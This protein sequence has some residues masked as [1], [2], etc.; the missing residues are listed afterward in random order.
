MYLR[1]GTKDLRLRGKILPSA[2]RAMSNAVITFM[3]LLSILSWW[4]AAEVF[5]IRE[6]SPH[7]VVTTVTL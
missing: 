1:H 7:Y 5:L 6:I 4:N 3:A 2:L